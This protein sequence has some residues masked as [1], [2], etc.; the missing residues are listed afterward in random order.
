MKIIYKFFILGLR[1]SIVCNSKNTCRSVQSLTK[2]PTKVIYNGINSQLFYPE[3]NKIKAYDE[4]V[5]TTVSRLIRSKR[6]DVL[7]KAVSK[8]NKLG[9]N[10]HLNILGNGPELLSLRALKNS[11]CLENIEF[12]GEI[13]H[14]MVP[15]KL[16]LSDI[17]VTCSETE[18][19]GNSTIEAY[20]CGLRI[21]AT[22]IDIHKE[23]GGEA[24]IFF[25][26]NSVDSLVI[27][28]QHCITSGL[29]KPFENKLTHLNLIET[30]KE[31]VK[32]YNEQNNIKV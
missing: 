25:K 2:T 20:F 31:L 6:I 15:D 24:F 29:K 32:F 13:P 27:A 16:R 5:V 12:F 28:L 18:G 14:D 7:I 30:N 8:L 11:L 3:K 4:I 9:Y 23:L 19:F 22:D 10:I 1:N 17:Y 21:I 26:K